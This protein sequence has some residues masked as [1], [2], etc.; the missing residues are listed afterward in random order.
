MM[1]LSASAERA[2]ALSDEQ[3]SNMAA[4]GCFRFKP[5]ALEAG[6]LNPPL[7]EKV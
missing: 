6:G 2:Q 3:M 7:H 4:A 5:D 1:G